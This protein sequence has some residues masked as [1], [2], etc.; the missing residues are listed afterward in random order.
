ML[1]LAAP[2]AALAKDKDAEKAAP[3]PARQVQ[4]DMK[5]PDGFYF[6]EKAQQYKKRERA[7]VDV[8][9]RNGTVQRRR[10][11]RTTCYNLQHETESARVFKPVPCND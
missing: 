7:V 6:D 11:I 9:D 4:T 10:V 5:L 2:A 1:L 3:P 8:P